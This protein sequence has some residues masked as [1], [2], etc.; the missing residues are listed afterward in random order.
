MTVRVVR[1]P[2]C[3]ST[4]LEMIKTLDPDA[5]FFNRKVVYWCMSCGHHWDALLTK[6]QPRGRNHL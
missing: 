1:C 4:R 5:T 6:I 2:K 3:N